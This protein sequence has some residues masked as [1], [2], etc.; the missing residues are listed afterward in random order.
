[1]K[2]I[3]EKI[4][5]LVKGTEARLKKLERIIFNEVAD[6]LSSNLFID[7]GEGSDLFIQKQ[8]ISFTPHNAGVI[9]S[10]DRL[11]SKFSPAI[12]KIGKYIISG[13]KSVLGLTTQQLTK[14]DVRA[15]KNSLIID[16]L[17]T[18]SATIINKDMTLEKIFTNI[19]QQAIALMTDPK[20]IDLK[21]LRSEL[22]SNIID[23]KLAQRYYSRWTHDL[24]SQMQ[25]VGANKI[26]LNLGLKYAIYQGG[27]IKTSRPFC[28]ERNGKC[29]SEE[30]INSW[31][32][33]EWEGKPEGYNAIVD[34]GGYN[35]RHRLDWVSEQMAKR[36]RSN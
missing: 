6:Y 28:E 9:A 23:N 27:L 32:T 31:N 24:Y 8:N 3:D 19:K 36:L 12:Q 17:L 22:K 16:E 21:E 29:F 26:R 33:E 5:E 4:D 30:E 1:M 15:E 34:C 2:E 20:G 13:I 18:H 10:I 7:V 14:V 35:C 25:R 11:L